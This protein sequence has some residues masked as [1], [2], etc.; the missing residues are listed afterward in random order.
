MAICMAFHYN[1]L[2]FDKR[3]AQSMQRSTSPLSHL[4]L[5]IILLLSACS[6]SSQKPTRITGQT[7]GTTY[8]VVIPKLPTNKTAV[9]LK[10]AIDKRLDDLNQNLSTWNPTSRLSLFNKSATTE[11]VE[12]PNE[13]V[14][15]VEAAAEVSRL[16]DGAYDITVS[17]LV[18]LWG[19]GAG[20]SASNTIPSGENIKTVLERVGY[21]KLHLQTQPP[22]L[23][24]S[25]PD[26]EIDLSSIAKGYGVD[27]I[28]IVLESH[29]IRRYLVE[30]GG[31]IQ[32]RGLSPRNDN[33]RVGVEKPN[34][35][36]AGAEEALHLKDAHLATSG[37]YRN[38]F[39]EN[40]V[41]YS[42]TIDARNGQTVKHK[43]AAVTVMHESTMLADAWATAL[44]VLGEE[45]GFELAK[46]Q[47]IAAFFIYRH[48]DGFKTR[49][50]EAFSPALES[51]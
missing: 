20:K 7:M 9:S 45:A 47:S 25:R 27:Q 12:L 19:F 32:T 29:E 1:H 33:W 35:E 46:K 49:H 40:G 18:D 24:K 28:G 37:D 2:Y 36:L 22:A 13:I 26:L 39:E 42:H 31:E 44:L 6:D 38:Y 5:I 3:H 50:T 41:R 16:S 17:P 34:S 23:K 15:L 48:S 14:M 11:W 43:L 4:V 8:T 10:T 21:N 51:E 30:I